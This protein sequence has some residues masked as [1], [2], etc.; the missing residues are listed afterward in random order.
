[1][2][3][4]LGVSLGSTVSKEIHSL[5]FSINNT[6]PHHNNKWQEFPVGKGKQKA[7]DELKKNISEAPVLMLP[8]LQ[9]LFEV[10]TNVSGYAMG[11]VLM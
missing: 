1:M 5:V 4:R 8:N 2:L 10:E 11:V 6:S 7:F 9:R 3:L